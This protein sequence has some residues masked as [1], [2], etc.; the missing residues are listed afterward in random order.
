MI[1]RLFPALLALAFAACAAL[2]SAAH[3]DDGLVEGRDYVAIANGQPLAAEPGKVEVVEVFAY[4]CQVC[5][6]FQ[7]HITR[8]R[9]TLADDVAFRYLPAAFTPADTY[10]RAYFAMDS[11]DAPA[12]THE[13]VYRAIH[14]EQSLPQRGASVDEFAT[15]LGGLGLDR[16]AAAAAMRSPGT[17][18]RMASARDFIV[19]SGIQGTPSMIVNGRYRALGRNF[20]D[21]LRITDLLVARAR[22]ATSDPSVSAP[23]EPTP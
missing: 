4:W 14:A 3:A 1:Q 12:G 5:N 19:A 6:D 9:R 7:P 13:A 21:M 20:G 22:A 23:D 10:A 16:A 8:W 11:L 18:A 15:L 17:E 2:P